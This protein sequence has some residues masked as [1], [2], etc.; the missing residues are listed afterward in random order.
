MNELESLHRHLARLNE[1]GIALSS[2]RDLKTLL[3]RILQEAR[4]FTR[5][6]AGSLY[7]VEK[8]AL[9]F[10]VTQNEGLRRRRGEPD[11]ST[12]SRTSGWPFP[13]TAWPV[14]SG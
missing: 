5:A 13:R 7:L 1:I 14:T 12:C 8:N 11:G 2:E 6:E 10:V 3:S 4:A 9:R